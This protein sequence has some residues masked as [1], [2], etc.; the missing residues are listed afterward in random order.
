MA[1]KKAYVE[2]IAYLEKNKDSKV[3]TILAGAI[4]L[5]SAKAGGGSGGGQ[6]FKKDA[7]GKV[8][9]VFCYYHKM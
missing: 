4:E 7:T 2:L 8:T 5:C 6:N 3:K 9:H 1:I